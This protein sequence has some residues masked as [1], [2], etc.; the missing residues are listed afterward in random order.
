MLA[1]IHVKDDLPGRDTVWDC[2]RNR[3]E[4]DGGREVGRREREKERERERKRKREKER[5]VVCACVCNCV[6]VC[7]SYSVA[8]ILLEWLTCTITN[9]LTDSH[10]I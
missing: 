7:V 10:V 6:H 9:I 8:I 2:K 4:R 5:V 3:R 1:I